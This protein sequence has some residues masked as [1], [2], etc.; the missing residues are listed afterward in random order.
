MLKDVFIEMF[1]KPKESAGLC[2][3]PGSMTIYS[4]VSAPKLQ[5][6][7]GTREESGT[8][9]VSTLAERHWGV[10]GGAGHGMQGMKGREA[11]YAEFHHSPDHLRRFFCLPCCAKSP[12]ATPG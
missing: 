7:E 8:D 4:A 6:G 2:A 12:K 9:H 3:Q 11:G 1:F 5:G 10:M